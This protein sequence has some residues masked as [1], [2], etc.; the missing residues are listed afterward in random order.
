MSAPPEERDAPV[1]DAAI[2]QQVEFGSYT[3]DLPI[4]LELA[5]EANGPVLELGAGSGRVAA[6][7]A[8][9]GH[10]VIALERDPDLIA[11][12]ERSTAELGVWVTAVRAQLASTQELELPAVPSLVIGPLHVVQVFDSSGRPAL[13]GRLLELIPPGGQMALTVV[14]ETTLLSAGA[15][16]TQIL[17]DMREV[18]GWVYSSEPL[19]VQ[20]GEDALTVRRVRERVS[21]EG[22]MQQSIHDEVLNR[23]SPERLEIEAEEVGFRPAGRRQI[24]SGPNEADSTVVLLE[25]PR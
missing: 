6:H 3:A 9:H 19:W 20:V 1:A 25:V 18:D 23:L 10:Q 4:W 7:L 22:A 15:A 14:D 12:L 13:L 16:A 8:E 21:P 17:P 2:W 5:E 11:A 24:S